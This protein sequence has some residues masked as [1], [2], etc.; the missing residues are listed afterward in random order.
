M[1]IN[2]QLKFFGLT[3][4]LTLLAACEQPQQPQQSQQQPTSKPTMNIPVYEFNG[5]SA[6]ARLEGT[7]L[8]KNGC[9]YLDEIL[10]ILPEGNFNW[11][12][13]QQVLT[14]YG[15]AYKVGQRAVFGGHPGNYQQDAGR[16]K[17]LSKQCKTEHIWFAG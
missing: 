5:I 6:T 4:L 14:L 12:D 17:Q 16:I 8:L 13:Q 10:P 9:L 2:N 1:H 7:L 15:N 11:D 3:V